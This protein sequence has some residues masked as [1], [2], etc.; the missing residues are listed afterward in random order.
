MY[1]AFFFFFEDTFNK[2]YSTMYHFPKRASNWIFT[3]RFTIAP[4]TNDTENK[5]FRDIITYINTPTTS[6]NTNK[7]QSTKWRFSG[8]N[9]VLLMKYK[10]G[11]ILDV[12]RYIPCPS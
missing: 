10:R 12:H 5:F 8:Y 9:F 4:L 11:H 6:W 2:N 3:Y 7:T 1:I